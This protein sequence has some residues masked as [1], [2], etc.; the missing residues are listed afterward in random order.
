MVVTCR[1]VLPRLAAGSAGRTLVLVRRDWRQ[2]HALLVRRVGEC[3]RAS[4]DRIGTEGQLA[5]PSIRRYRTGIALVAK[6]GQPGQESPKHRLR[7]SQLDRFFRQD[8]G[9]AD[10]TPPILPVELK[11]PIPADLEQVIDQARDPAQAGNEHGANQL[12]QRLWLTHRILPIEIS[13]Q[14]TAPPRRPTTPKVAGTLRVP[15]APSAAAPGRPSATARGACL[16]L[17]R[18]RDVSRCPYDITARPGA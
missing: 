3:D 5:R 18:P 4:D 6:G 2:F 11:P 15:S 9:R 1:Q 16:L 17:S 13:A 10:A 14:R 8:S 12:R 7:Q